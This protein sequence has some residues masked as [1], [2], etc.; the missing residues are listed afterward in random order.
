MFDE[1][2]TKK[3]ITPDDLRKSHPDNAH[4]T[5]EQAEEIIDT[6]ERFAHIIVSHV[7]DLQQIGAMDEQGNVDEN[8]P[9]LVR[10]REAVFGK[11]KEYKKRGRKKL[12]DEQKTVNRERKRPVKQPPVSIKLC[13]A[14]PVRG[15]LP[16]NVNSIKQHENTNKENSSALS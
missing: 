15:I 6:I 8:H 4:Y 3:R 13:N 10:R 12:S 2:R 16:Q 14:V 1:E 7:M 5:D 11:P 9:E